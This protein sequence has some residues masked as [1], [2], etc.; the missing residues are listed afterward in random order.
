MKQIGHLANLATE[1]IQNILLYLPIDEKLQN[2][3]L[4]SKSLFAASIYTSDYFSQAHYNFQTEIEDEKRRKRHFALSERYQHVAHFLSSPTTIYTHFPHLPF[5][6]QVL[7][8]TNG[9]KNRDRHIGVVR[10]WLKSEQQHLRLL[11]QAFKIHN[12]QILN[13]ESLFFEFVTSLDHI[14]IVLYLHDCGHVSVDLV[15]H[16]VIT[17]GLVAIL[18][19]LLANPSVEPSTSRLSHIFFEKVRVLQDTL[20]PNPKWPNAL[21][22]TRILLADGRVDPTYDGNHQL[23][24]AVKEAR[25]DFVQLFLSD[26]RVDPTGASVTA[27]LRYICQRDYYIHNEVNTIKILLDD[28]RVDPVVIRDCVEAA[29]NAGN[30]RL[31]SLL[32][33]Y[34]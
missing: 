19:Q 3:G 1:T 6:Y 21:E 30:E 28:G 7:A 33:Q 25:P 34:C 32:L 13:H 16:Y 5:R 2:V 12:H 11:K 22:I 23:G 4:A 24:K 10:Q 20:F 9:I 18:Q 31:G 14:N 15:F 8:Y 29:C 17:R 27:A 26:S